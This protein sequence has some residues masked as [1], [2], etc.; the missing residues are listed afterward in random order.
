MIPKKEPYRS[1]FFIF[2]VIFLTYTFLP[3]LSFADVCASQLTSDNQMRFGYNGT[4]DKLGAERFIAASDCHVVEISVDLLA[5][6]SPS[7]DVTLKLYSESADRPATL[8]A[9]GTN[10]DV[11]G[12][13][14]TYTSDIE[15][16]LTNGTEYF[17]VLGRTGAD[18]TTNYYHWRGKDSNVGGIFIH[19]NLPSSWEV[20]DVT[21]GSG[22][23]TVTSGEPSEEEATT[24]SATTTSITVSQDNQD[25]FNG[26]L[27]FFLGMWIIIYIF[28]R[29]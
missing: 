24:T 11:T 21:G 29:R 10:L 3:M 2:W 23:Y 20:W 5:S 22:V 17:I 6:G 28:K 12:G 19:G 25:L 1:Y 9:T 18:D 14:A 4:T 8:L 15:Y 13:T 7:D 27:L 16:D 26:F